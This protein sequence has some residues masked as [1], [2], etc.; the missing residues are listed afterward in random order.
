MVVNW[1]KSN[2]CRYTEFVSEHKKG[3]FRGSLRSNF[4]KIIDQS[5]VNGSSCN[6]FSI[7]FKINYPHLVG[8]PKPSTAVD[9]GVLLV[10][11]TLIR[12]TD[13][14]GL[15]LLLLLSSEKLAK[16]LHPTSESSSIQTAEMIVKC[17]TIL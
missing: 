7:I 12:H 5:N 2:V 9:V 3:G 13:I 10:L 17:H 16:S 6:L 11:D 8:P 14:S 4:D 1:P 15:L